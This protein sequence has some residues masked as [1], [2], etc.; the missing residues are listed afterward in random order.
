M[1]DIYDA[2]YEPLKAEFNM[3][4]TPNLLIASIIVYF[5]ISLAITFFVLPK[6]DKDTDYTMTFL[7]GG[8]LGLLIYGIYDLT[9]Y[10]L[11]VEWPLRIAI[12]D[13]CWGFL[14]FGLTTMVVRLLSSF[15]K[16]H[17]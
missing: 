17:A 11:F 12:M 15:I 7:W 2:A 14:V 13:I 3:D 16:P 8:F 5:F 6:F 1:G 4:L 9:N 10:L